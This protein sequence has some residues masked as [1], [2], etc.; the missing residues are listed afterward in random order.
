ML[1][2]DLIDVTDRPIDVTDRPIDT[3]A[4]DQFSVSGCVSISDNND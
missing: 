4:H 1:Q 3:V 2:I